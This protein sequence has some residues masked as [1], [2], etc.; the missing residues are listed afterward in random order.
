MLV[1][2]HWPLKAGTNFWCFLLRNPWFLR[3]YLYLL[4]KII[5][6]F[7]N[8]WRLWWWLYDM[9]RRLVART[10]YQPLLC[11]IP[12]G[13]KALFCKITNTEA[14]YWPTRSRRS[15]YSSLCNWVHSLCSPWNWNFKKSSAFGTAIC[16]WKWFDKLGCLL[17]IELAQWI[18]K[19]VCKWIFLNLHIEACAGLGLQCWFLKS[20]THPHNTTS[21]HVI[22]TENLKTQMRH[23]KTIREE[24]QIMWILIPH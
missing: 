1:Q 11:I 20:Q 9:S 18:L 13:W 14:K 15:F 3:K 16:H 12:L 10:A 22:S 6:L 17:E 7:V 2:S 21:Q 5:T 8:L 24:K 23:K 19:G 4:L